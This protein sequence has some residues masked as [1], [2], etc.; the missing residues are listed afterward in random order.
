MC[1]QG[2]LGI[3]GLVEALFWAQIKQTRQIPEHPFPWRAIKHTSLGKLV[4]SWHQ[5]QTGRV[6]PLENIKMYRVRDSQNVLSGY[7]MTAMMHMD[8]WMESGSELDLS[9]V[10]WQQKA[11]NLMFLEPGW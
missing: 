4:S 6:N 3:V 9:A 11:S 5:G 8:G 2:W 1:D 10:N 7:E